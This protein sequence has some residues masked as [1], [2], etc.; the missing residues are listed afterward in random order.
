MQRATVTVLFTDLVASTAL[1]AGLDRD[2]ADRVRQRHFAVLRQPLAIHEGTEVKNLGDGLMVVF[3][4][5][6]AALACAEAMQ[7]AVETARRDDPV[8]LDI[9]IGISVGEA[10]LE[11]DDYFGDPVVEAARLCAAADGGQILVADVVRALAGRRTPHLFVPVGDLR[12]KGLPEPIPTLE[13]TWLPASGLAGGIPLPK[14]LETP[15]GVGFFGRD[16]VVAVAQQ[17]WKS[18]NAG[19]G[20]QLLLVAGEP[21]MGKTTLAGEIGR[22]S[23]ESG[24]V[25]LYG[26]CDQD[27]GIPYQPFVEA[28]GH[29]VANADEADLQAHVDRHGASLVRLLPGLQRRLPELTA[30][31]ADPDTDRYLLYAA[32]SGLLTEMAEQAP[33]LLVLDDLQWAD[34]PT[35]SLLRH[36]ADGSGDPRLLVV[37]NYRQSDLSADHALTDVLAQLHRLPGV[38]RLALTGLDDGDIVAYMERAAGHELDRTGVALAHDVR[39][40]TNGNPYFLGE[41]LRHLLDTGSVYEED[42]HWRVRGDL[43]DQ[44]LPQSIR[45]VVGQRVAGLPEGT[46]TVLA[47]A[48]VVGREFDFDLLAAVTGEDEDR[49]LDLLDGAAEAAVIREVEPG[50]YA[51]THALSQQALSAGLGAT[52]RAR[53]HQRIAEAMEDQYGAAVAGR[54]GELAHHWLQA[55]RAA[56]PER[57]LGYA[58]RAGE[59]ALDQLAPDEAIRWYGEALVVYDQLVEPDLLLRCDLLTGLGSAQRQA[60]QPHRESLREAFLLAREAGDVDRLVRAVLTNS[61]G[62]VSSSGHLQEDWIA[63]LEEALAAIGPADSGERALLQSALASELMF[64]DHDRRHALAEE[65]LA[66]AVRLGDPA[67]ELTVLN[68]NHIATAEPATLE[69]RTE[70]AH[71]A[72]VLAEQ[73]GDRVGQWF[74]HA[75]LGGVAME[76]G[77]IDGFLEHLAHEEDLA[78]RVG[79][80]FLAW[81]SILHRQ[82]AEVLAGNLESAERLAFEGFQVGTDGGVPEAEMDLGMQLYAVRRSQG[83][84]GDL[85]AAFSEAMDLNPFPPAMHALTAN[86][87]CALGELDAARERFAPLAENRF[88][89]FEVDNMWL[90]AIAVCAE[91]AARL[92]DVDAAG[93]LLELLAPWSDQNTWFQIGCWGPVAYYLGLS[94][95]AVGRHDD[96]DAWFDQALAVSRDRL[97]SPYWVARTQVEWARALTGR[98]RDAGALLDE[99]TTTAEEF[100]F[101]G[102]TRTAAAVTSP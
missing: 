76:R 29:Y 27:M 92:D 35:L 78:R 45:E 62:S 37:G 39:R 70:R 93:T 4:R 77:D 9:R 38:Q 22:S 102:I 90:G 58:R 74:A 19:E 73:S 79:R 56:D 49:L 89:D 24:G 36:L 83:D 82:V 55:T 11:D 63:E 80:P 88:E 46:S 100:G 18:V 71:R 20:R 10:T 2:E 52:R 30:P 26:R 60:G 68:Q 85:V 8:P 65:S 75:N 99:A 96:A 40:E 61:R 33:V 42:G 97:R 91:T 95:T 32:V 54:V 72:L 69:L 15:P 48:A 50:R 87:L 1:T 98:G 7:Q 41:L 81:L 53:L 31:A 57:T 28:L 12:L 13:L 14:R 17:S 5:S 67:V 84:L 6:S 86:D 64:T 21:G 25:V 51:F 101:D 44:G 59:L 47:V 94:A 43:A 34:Q 3:D 23:H 16:E 66:I